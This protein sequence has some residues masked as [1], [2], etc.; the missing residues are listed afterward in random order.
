MTRAKE[1]LVIAGTQGRNKIPDGCWYQLVEDA[2]KADCVAEPA[3][4]GDGEVCVTAKRL[5][6]IE[7]QTSKKNTSPGR[8]QA[9]SVPSWL[10]I[11][12]QL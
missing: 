5:Q 6:N 9:N 2:L 3:D 4:D 11:E 1:R 10:T 8:D 7:A 12:R